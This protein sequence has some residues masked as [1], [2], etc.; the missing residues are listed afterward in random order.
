LKSSSWTLLFFLFTTHWRPVSISTLA[1]AQGCGEFTLEFSLRTKLTSIKQLIGSHLAR[2][3]IS[4]EKL[5]RIDTDLFGIF[6]LL[7]GVIHLQIKEF[8]Q[9]ILTNA[10]ERI[11]TTL[12]LGR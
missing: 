3:S 4:S 11:R 8:L 5:I 6:I 1:F 2:L 7:N 12:N 10:P 9:Q